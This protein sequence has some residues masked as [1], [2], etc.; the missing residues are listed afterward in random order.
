MVKPST[1]ASTAIPSPVQADWMLSKSQVAAIL[2]SLTAQPTAV[3]WAKSPT[4]LARKVV[5]STITAHLTSGTALSV[6]TAFLTAETAFL[7]AAQAV[8][9]TIVVH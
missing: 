2:I 9:Y 1:S 3:R 7:T 5:A 4:I 6:A 8:A